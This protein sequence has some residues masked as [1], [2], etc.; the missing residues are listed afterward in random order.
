MYMTLSFKLP[1]EM[2]KELTLLSQEE[3]VSEDEILQR[4]FTLYLENY[5]QQKHIVDDM[6]RGYTEM[7]HINITIAE[8]GVF[9]SEK[10]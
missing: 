2:K 6:K 10:K 8:E 9:G 3:N 7:G 5:K 1:E 4:A